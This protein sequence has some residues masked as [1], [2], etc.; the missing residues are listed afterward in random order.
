MGRKRV[1]LPASE[2]DMTTVKYMPQRTQGP[3]LTGFWLKLSVMLAEL[4]IIGSM[5]MTL[6]KNKNRGAEMYKYTMIPETPLFAPEFPPQESEPDVVCLEEDGKPE[7]RVELALQCLSDYNP[8]SICITDSTTPFRYW[9]IRDYAYA[10]RSQLTTP[11]QVAE[12]FISAIEDSKNQNPPAPLLISYDPDEIRRQAASSTQRF[13]EGSELS[14]LDGIFIAVKDDIDCYPYPSKGATTWFHEM[15]EVKKD[16]V[17]VSRLRSC[18]AV[19]VGKTNM[20]ELAM[21]TTGNNPNFG[22]PRNPHDPD[23]YT[24]GSSS[25]SAAIVASG[26]CPAALGTDGGGS[27]RVP[28][29]LCGVVGLKTTYGRTDIKGLI[30]TSST[31]ASV[32][33]ITATVEDATLVYAAILG[34]SPAERVS[35]KPALPCLPNLSSFESYSSLGSL[36]FGKY[37]EWF[38]DV[39]STEISDKCD[40]ILNQLSEKHG[41]KVKLGGLTSINFVTNYF[42]SI[43]SHSCFLNFFF[44]FL[45]LMKTIEIVIPELHEMHNALIVSLGSEALSQLNPYVDNGKLAR[46][47]CDTR[48]NLAIF[49]AFTASEYVVAQCLRQRFMYYHMEIFKKVDIIVT[50]TTAMTATIISPSALT[51]GETNIP[52]VGNLMRFVVA[53]NLLGFPAISVPVGYD[54]QGLPIGMQLIGRPWSEASILRVAAAIE[55]TCAGPKK[56]PVQFYD[57]LKGNPM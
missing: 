31:V 56:K 12:D 40:D 53:G 22:T 2:I 55:E 52:V 25:G 57:I 19:F 43:I 49:R 17:C 30:Y 35:L 6:V 36:R 24:G 9:K 23:R 21:G 33:P 8:G 39:F 14:I 26:L 48:I 4:P 18:G 16:A 13:K 42:L 34:S 50:P 47:T 32:G 41:V 51:A 37:T 3:H 38:N 20:H 7:E 45:P 15:H 28:S 29:S 10:Y 54:K 1:M 27:I 5:I 44:V 11:S 46:L